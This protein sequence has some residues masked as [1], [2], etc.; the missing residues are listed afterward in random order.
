[1]LKKRFFILLPQLFITLLVPILSSCVTTASVNKESSAFSSGHISRNLTDRGIKSSESLQK[2]FLSN[3]PN[4]DKDMVKRMADY[5]IEESRTEGINSDCAF[6]QMCLETG[7]LKFGGLVTPDM[8]NYCGLGSMDAQHPGERFETEQMGVRAHI[9]HLHA[10]A[11]S[12]SI[13]LK[14][15]CIDT[16]Y[17]Y[18]TPRGKSP[19]IYN[20]TG[21][22][23]MD[24]EYSVKINI[25]LNKL[26]AF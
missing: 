10:Y 8:H 5:Y 17:R 19:S 4:A 22:W 23:A 20:L 3:N 7:F 15:P 13:P 24:R 21:T 26:E 6:V 2:F 12:E 9:Q 16:R 25:L 1:M 14:N 18:V 11:T